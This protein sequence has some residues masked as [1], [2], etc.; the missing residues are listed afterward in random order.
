VHN[1]LCGP[2]IREYLWTQH[3]HAR[4]AAMLQN[5]GHGKAAR[6]QNAIIGRQ[7]CLIHILAQLVASGLDLGGGCPHRVAFLYRFGFLPFHIGNFR[8][9]CA[10]GSIQLRV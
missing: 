10:L 3:N 9:Q 4:R 6:F 2:D 1:L 8:L 5:L 7:Q